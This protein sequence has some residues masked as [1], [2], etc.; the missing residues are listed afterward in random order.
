MAVGNRGESC[1]QGGLGFDPV[2]LAGFDQRCDAALGDTAFIMASE[3][4]VLA[5]EGDG[6]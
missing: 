4:G 1:L 2:D 5:V 3:E 6:A